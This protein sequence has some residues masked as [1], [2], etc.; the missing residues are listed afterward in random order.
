M[1]ILIAAGVLTVTWC[2]LLIWVAR[3]AINRGRSAVVWAIIAGGVGVLGVIAGFKIS[4]AL[5]DGVELGAVR[6]TLAMFMPVFTLIASMVA[7]GL[8][9]YREP[10][11][12]STKAVWPVTFIGKGNGSISFNL[13]KIQIAVGDD[14]R[15]VT[16][17][18]LRKVEADGECVRITLDD[19]ELNAMP[20]GKPATPAGRRHQSLVLAKRM[21]G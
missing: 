5:L 18:Q 9:V 20:M 8:V 4:D 3:I 17:D 6:T 21:R 14:V 1:S 10:I 2:L 19:A 7:V 16:Q 12:V 11:K 13:T 15:E